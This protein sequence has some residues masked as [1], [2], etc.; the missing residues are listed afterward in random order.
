[1]LCDQGGKC[2]QYGNYIEHFAILHTIQNGMVCLTLN[3]LVEHF[4]NILQCTTL[5]KLPAFF[6]RSTSKPRA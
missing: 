1:M 5:F 4:K 3:A 6:F 2:M